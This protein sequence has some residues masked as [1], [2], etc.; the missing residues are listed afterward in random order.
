MIEFNVFL[1]FLLAL[2]LGALIGAERERFGGS[3]VFR[4]FGGLRTF[5]FITLFGSLS[6]FISNVYFQWFIIPA[7]IGLIVLVSIGYLASVWSSKGRDLGL[8]SEVTALL[9]FLLGMLIFVSEPVYSVGLAIILTT[10]LYL[11]N[12]LHSFVKTLSREEIYSTLVFAII[13]FVVLPFLPDK[14][15][16]PLGVINPYNIWLMVVFISGLSYV[17]Y[18][19]IKIMGPKK[20]IGFTGLLGGLVSSTAVTLSMASDSKKKVYESVVGL[21]VFATVIANSVM[22][23][24]VLV[25]VYVVNKSL[26]SS[27]VVPM[28]LMA[29]VGFSSALFFWFNRDKK[30]VSSDLNVVHTSPFTLKPAL[31][32]AFFFS[33]VLLSV[34]LAQIYLG[35]SGVFA[36]SV[37]SGLID[38]DAITLTMANLA[39]SELSSNTAVTAI[40]LAVLS[41]TFVK[42]VY[43]FIFG[44]RDFRKKLSIVFLL[45]IISGLL[46][47]LLF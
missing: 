17:G 2:A 4:I 30:I 22:F 41:N 18:F 42:F 31:K 33:L 45:I 43:A 15:Y 38:V 25:E 13:A 46:A 23:L 9:A 34:K 37:L 44:S 12:S 24:R 6:V 10:L 40:T 16:D 39:H 5:M 47:I 20:G 7:F 35:T 29:V 1:K 8:S 28:L 19:L 11:K 14:A 36:A 27:L 3:G 26:L 21:L 32:F